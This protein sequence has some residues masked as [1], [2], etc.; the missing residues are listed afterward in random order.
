MMEPYKIESTNPEPLVKLIHT[1]GG[2]CVVE[3]TAIVT[4]YMFSE[5][6]V[7]YITRFTDTYI[8]RHKNLLKT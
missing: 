6:E 5:M 7:D 1:M 3:G 4:D 2:Q 8:K